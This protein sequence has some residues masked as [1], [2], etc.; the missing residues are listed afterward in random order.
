M[1]LGVPA[2]E[3]QQQTE[4]L[5]ISL[6]EPFFGPAHKYRTLSELRSAEHQFDLRW[7]PVSGE[8]P[9]ADRTLRQSRIRETSG[10]SVVG[11]LREGKLDVNPSPDFRLL[12]GDLVAAIGTEAALQTLREMASP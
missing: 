2:S 6:F 7:L 1:Q 11:V 3:V 4:S 10:A 5:R 9:L 12:A 8:S